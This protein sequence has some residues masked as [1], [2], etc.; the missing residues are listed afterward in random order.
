MR[1]FPRLL[2]RGD[3]S[4]ENRLVVHN[5][6]A[7][8]AALSEGWREAKFP[9]PPEPDVKRKPGRPRKDVS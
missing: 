5:E 4:R 1:E 7:C 2:Y 8:D 3:G 6:D 9:I